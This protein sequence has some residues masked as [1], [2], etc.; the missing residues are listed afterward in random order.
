MPRSI[1]ITNSLFSLVAILLYVNED[2]EIGKNMRNMDEYEDGFS[3]FVNYN[4]KITET[5]HF[6]NF[7]FP[8]KITCIL[9]KHNLE[10]MPQGWMHA[11]II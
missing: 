3:H 4:M 6:H 7:F 8:V 10:F 11:G 5:V 1:P 2:P 9:R